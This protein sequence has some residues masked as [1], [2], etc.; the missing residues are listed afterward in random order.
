[1]IKH[2]KKGQNIRFK[3]IY[4][5][6]TRTGYGAIVLHIQTHTLL[7]SHKHQQYPYALSI[8]LKCVCVEKLQSIHT[9]L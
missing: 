7:L 6:L 2:I 4:F 8:L 1:M 9:L 3:S 5:G